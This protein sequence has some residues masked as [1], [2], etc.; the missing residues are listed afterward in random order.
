VIGDIFK[1]IAEVLPAVGNL[2]A[3]LLKL[4]KSPSEAAEIINRDMKSRQAEYE[5]E[6]AADDKAL[7]DK[8]NQG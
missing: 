3:A 6:K 8:H 7:E 4:G 2:A 1:V 5:R